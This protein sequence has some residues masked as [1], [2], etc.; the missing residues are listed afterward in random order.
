MHHTRSAL[1]QHFRFPRAMRSAR[2]RQ[3][4]SQTGEARHQPE[5][6]VKGGVGA[7]GPAESEASTASKPPAPSEPVDE[8]NATS[9]PPAPSEQVDEGAH[10][11]T[12]SEANATSEPPA[13]SE[14]VDEDM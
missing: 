4:E 8:V 2:L 14:Q 10:E 7:R 1:I 12:E 9:E 11:P 3:R 5:P 13:P 6:G